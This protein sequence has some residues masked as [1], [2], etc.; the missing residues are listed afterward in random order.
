MH[1]MTVA[2]I[3]TIISV[4]S[5]I[6][7]GTQFSASVR[8]LIIKWRQ[9]RNFTW[10]LQGHDS[11]TCRQCW[12]FFVVFRIICILS[13]SDL[14]GMLFCLNINNGSHWCSYTGYSQNTN[15][16]NNGLPVGWTVVGSWSWPCWIWICG[17]KKKENDSM[18]CF[19]NNKVGLK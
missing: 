13:R 5:I 12:L 6:I 11:I 19:T 4:L 18:K 8:S 7:T 15:N 14:L 17:C 1:E 16:N 9:F 2:I 10:Y 3:T